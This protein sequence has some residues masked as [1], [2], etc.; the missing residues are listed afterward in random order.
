MSGYRAGYISA[1]GRA[2]DGKKWV[3]PTQEQLAEH[4][5][6]HVSLN[7]VTTLPDVPGFRTVESYGI[8]S[9]L[10]AA[11]GFT[12]GTKG[13]DALARAQGQ[14]LGQATQMGANAVVGV[15]GS[16]FGAGGGITSAFG[17]DAVGIM[18]MGTAVRVE[19][20]EA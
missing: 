19:P 14:L 10:A 6:T 7:K 20:L 15:V 16:S 13:N 17:G 11:S 1:D 5:K 4:S 8:V 9:V 18:L 12:A 3:A 2:W